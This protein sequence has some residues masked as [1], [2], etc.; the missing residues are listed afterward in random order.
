MAPAE[1]E[2]LVK[3][4]TIEGVD[5]KWKKKMIWYFDPGG[6]LIKKD[7]HG[8][9]GKGTW[10]ID[11]KGQFCFQDKHKKQEK[12]VSNTIKKKI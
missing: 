8:N 12:N 6:R 11:K 9:K 7:E 5:V 3:G 1:A 10:S 4:N 2:N